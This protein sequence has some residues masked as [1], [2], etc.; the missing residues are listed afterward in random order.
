MRLL[1]LREV[2]N[3]CRR[4]VCVLWMLELLLLT[5]TLADE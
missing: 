2:A 3:L 5:P 4:F 1:L